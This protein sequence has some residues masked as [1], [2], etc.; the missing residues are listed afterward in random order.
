[1]GDQKKV[2]AS[3]QEA[4]GGVSLKSDEVQRFCG[5]VKDSRYMDKA[6]SKISYDLTL[7]FLQRFHPV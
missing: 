5:L 6:I 2:K 1:M 4:S 3:C 7:Y